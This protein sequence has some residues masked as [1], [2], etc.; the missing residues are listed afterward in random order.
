VEPPHLVKQH[1][2]ETYTMKMNH[3][4]RLKSLIDSAFHA[5]VVSIQNFRIGGQLLRSRLNV[6]NTRKLQSAGLTPGVRFTA[7]YAPGIIDLVKDEGGA[8]VVSP[9]R[10]VKRDGSVELGGRIDLRSLQ[11]HENLGDEESALALYLPGRIVFL[12]LPS[13]ARNC[14]RIQRLLDAVNAGQIQTVALYAGVGT[15]DAALH[16]GFAKAGLESE[17]VLA[18]DFWEGAIDC[19][20]ADN[21][22]SGRKTKSFAGGIEQ[23]IAS[24]MRVPGTT[25]VTIGIPAKG[26]RA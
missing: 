4:E 11:V 24:G 2:E 21:P 8:N 18:N 6:E 26:R 14:D 15:L 16:E 13:V 5:A 1:D 3:T 9:K 20:L 17:T 19:L 23:F 7:H 12:H 10:L 22:A 25:M